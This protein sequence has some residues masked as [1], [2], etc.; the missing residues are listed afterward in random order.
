MPSLGNLVSD[1]WPWCRSWPQSSSCCYWYW[2]ICEGREL[3]WSCMGYVC[4][5]MII[6]CWIVLWLY[7]WR[8]YEDGVSWMCLSM[9][10]HLVNV[11]VTSVACLILGG[12]VLDGF[13]L[14]L[15]VL[16]VLDVSFFCW[17]FGTNSFWGGDCV[18]PLDWEFLFPRTR[19]FM[20][21]CVGTHQRPGRWPI[22]WLGST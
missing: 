17:E 21:G 15:C 4:C 6:W 5:T 18:I 12:V 14:V 22:L 16:E 20:M 13:G 11:F 9:V 19:V 1:W 3:A 8:R 10:L 7:W 2:I